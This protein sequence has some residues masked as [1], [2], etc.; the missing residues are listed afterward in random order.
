MPALQLAPNEKVL[1]IYLNICA[2]EEELKQYIAHHEIPLSMIELLTKLSSD[3]RKAIF[4]LISHL[5]IGTNKLKELLTFLDEIALRDNCSIHQILHEEAIHDLLQH[6]KYS[7]P[8]KIEQIRQII[9]KKRYPQLTTLEQEYYTYLKDLRLPRGLQVKTDRV[10]EDDKLTTT[11][12][13]STPA[14]LKTFAEDLLALAEKPE[15]QKLLEL[16]QGKV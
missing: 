3:D 9:R 16:I 6:E 14:E 15:L 2:C 11:F 1:E 5:K 10:F 7:G 4:A 13:F 12:R 8:Q